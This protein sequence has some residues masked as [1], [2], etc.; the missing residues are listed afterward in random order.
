MQL[1]QGTFNGVSPNGLRRSAVF[2]AG[3]AVLDPVAVSATGQRTV[4]L[5]GAAPISTHAAV[6]FRALCR[7]DAQVVLLANTA[8]TG[9]VRKAGS[10]A[11]QFSLGASLFYSRTKL[12]EGALIL[13]LAA[14]ADVG[15]VFIS[16]DAVVAPVSLEVAANRK[17]WSPGSATLGVSSSLSASATRRTTGRLLLNFTGGLDPA[18]RKGGVRYI[19]AGMLAPLVTRAEDGGVVRGRQMGA[20]PLIMSAR[21]SAS[22]IRALSGVAACSLQA[23]GDWSVILRAAMGPVSIGL[24]ASLDGVVLVRGEGV[25]DKLLIGADLTGCVY[26]RGEATAAFPYLEAE[27]ETRKRVGLAGDAPVG[28][29]M[30][31]DLV[32]VITADMRLPLE[33]HVDGSALTRRVPDGALD[34]SI[35]AS[36]D[37]R[38][39]VRLRG[40]TTLASVALDPLTAT[41]TTHF[42]A[43]L[44]GVSPV[45]L[46]GGF[47][48]TRVGDGEVVCT[49]HAD[50]TGTLRR[51]PEILAVIDV[52][53]SSSGFR[54]PTSDDIAKQRFERG[55]TARTFER[56]ETARFERTP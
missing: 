35:D 47:T 10:G 6:D 43:D 28:L 1:N 55:A 17:R 42:S 39:R 44:H 2:Y 29:G 5:S 16:G 3:S 56:Q 11:A 14:R 21:G 36:L 7:G 48:C 45:D 12:L 33:L 24:S 13:D 15:V 38:R 8:F 37:G 54:N 52:L 25:A 22:R 19:T 50:A 31:G 40:D 9:Q 18:A 51:V 30:T 4:R 53:T 27:W 41:R 23:V 20:L 46:E 32:R 34:L 49:V 26:K